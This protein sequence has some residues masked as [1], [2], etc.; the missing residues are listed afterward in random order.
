MKEDKAR[1]VAEEE[2]EGRRLKGLR[3]YYDGVTRDYSVVVRDGEPVI[4]RFQKRN[5]YLPLGINTLIDNPN[6][7]ENPGY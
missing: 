6:L 1:R 7:V 4:R 2:M 3:F 5:Y